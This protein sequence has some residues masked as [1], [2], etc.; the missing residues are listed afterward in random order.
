MI[1][2]IL[3]PVPGTEATNCLMFFWKKIN[4]FIVV[5]HWLLLSQIVPVGYFFKELRT[6]QVSGQPIRSWQLQL[7]VSSTKHL[8][9]QISRLKHRTRKTRLVWRGLNTL[10]YS[11]RTQTL[12]QNV[13][14]HCSDLETRNFHSG[15]IAIKLFMVVI[16]GC[17]Q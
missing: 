5:Q 17:L 10:V 3:V 4:S 14:L 13:L 12:L 6:S 16:Y 9:S 8:A 1:L 2:L 11:A 7:L 15:A